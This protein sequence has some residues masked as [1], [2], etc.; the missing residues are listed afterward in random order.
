MSF[1][2]NGFVDFRISRRACIAA[3]A[4]GPLIATAHAQDS[5]PELVPPP[6]CSAATA[7]SGALKGV[8]EVTTLPNGR[9]KVKVNLTAQTARIQVGGYSVVTENY[10][11]RYLSPVVEAMAGDTVAARLVNLLAPRSSNL[12][13]M[14]HGSKNPTN[15]HYFHGGIVTPRNARPL[16]AR[17]GTGDN[18]YVYLK[19]GLSFDYSVPIPGEGE[20]NGLVLEKAGHRIA[21]PDGLNWYHSHLHGISSDQVMGGLSGLLSV[22]DA[23]ANVKA[24][25]RPDPADKT[26]CRNDVAGDTKDLKARTDVRYALLRDI[27]LKSNVP[28]EAA[29]G[30]DA[31]WAPE[32]K[33]WPIDAG[34][35]Q[36][37][38]KLRKGFCL[39]KEDSPWLFTLNG[40]RFP[41]I[42]VEGG[43][44]LLLRLGNLSANVAYWLELQNE[45]DDK[46][47]LPLYLLSLDG[48]VPSRPV[49]VPE[50]SQPVA[51]FPVTDLLLMPAS[52]AEIYVRNDDKRTKSRFYI[53]RTKGLT[54]GNP[55]NLKN[56]NWP[57]IQLARIEL[58]PSDVESTI[59]V[60]L[61]PPV[62]TP[63]A[64]PLFAPPSAPPI[65]QGCVRDLDPEKGEHRRVTFFD[66][67]PNGQSWSI[68]TEIVHPPNG[69]AG[70]PAQE[71]KF[72]ADP[73]ATVGILNN[74]G[75]LTGGIPFKE[76]DL[77]DGKI[78]WLGSKIM[79]DGRRL[80]HPCVYLDPAHRSSHKQLWVLVNKTA[81]LH[82]FHIHQMKFRLATATEL[83]EHKIIPGDSHTCLDPP[84]KCTQPDY[85]LYDDEKVDPKTNAPLPVKW[86]DTIPV[87]PG[88]TKRVY[89]IMSF[90]ASQQVGRYVFHCHILKHEDNDLMAPF[91]VWGSSTS[92]ALNKRRTK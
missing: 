70:A 42:T 15:L 23:K 69:V 24:A 78:D 58:K 75:E 36:P 82:N 55:D 84:E 53:L 39:R 10:N 4:L 33:D 91:E 9:K 85:K 6:V 35:C 65:P 64:G 26:K 20:L 18:I 63:V 74:L 48:V 59:D 77:G 92:A 32:D 90:D 19:R 60:A 11:A 89:L 51:A 12:H 72:V 76:Y 47:I 40:Q 31:V 30:E 49:D 83:A 80:L 81:A 61:N 44:N 3:V 67:P 5:R 25:C 27:S 1:I 29:K 45:D 56:D 66:P 8:C 41:A 79:S 73:T 88:P 2:S 28:P 52:R 21:H 43:K 86:H 38:P 46:D 87:P 68:A 14:A 22:G 7:A 50:S 16:D 34:E 71:R 37:A 13:G 57:A 54:A 17:L 62:A